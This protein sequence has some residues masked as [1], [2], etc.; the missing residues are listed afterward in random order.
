MVCLFTTAMGYT[1]LS[2][3]DSVWKIVPFKE[4]RAEEIT[5]IFKLTVASSEK[6]CTVYVEGHSDVLAC[7]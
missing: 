2:E 3:I 6:R 1:K 4:H 5:Q 7:R